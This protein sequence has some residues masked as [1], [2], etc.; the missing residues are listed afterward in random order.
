M[1]ILLQVSDQLVLLQLARRIIHLYKSEESKGDTVGFQ[2]VK[3]SDGEIQYNLPPPQKKEEKKEE[4]MTPIQ[5]KL[6]LEKKLKIKYD[7]FLPP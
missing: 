6:I 7:V 1:F 3:L 2:I 5:R 4:F